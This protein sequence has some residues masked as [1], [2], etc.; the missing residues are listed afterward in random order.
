MEQHT[1]VK[2]MMLSIKLEETIPEECYPDL[3][4]YLAQIYAVGFDEGRND[5]AFELNR[6]SCKAIGQ[7]RLDGSLVSTFKSLHEAC[8]KTGFSKSGILYSMQ[9]GIPT[10]QRWVWKYLPIV[11]KKDSTEQKDMVES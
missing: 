10:R 4:R 8:R 9:Y 3:R 7:Y 6:H 5:K 11:I 1:A 2:K